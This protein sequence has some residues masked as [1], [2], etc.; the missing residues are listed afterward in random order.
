[1][2]RRWNAV[3]VAVVVIG[4][5]GGRKDEAKGTPTGKVSDAG[6]SGLPMPALGVEAP[7][8]LNYPYGSGAND[9][10]RAVAAYKAKPRDWT[11]VRSACEATLAKDKDH[12]DAHRLLASA[13]AQAGD[14]AGATQQLTIA[15]AADW[16][17][18]G[19]ALASDPELAAYLASPEGKA[20]LALSDQMKQA[21][22][23]KSA[24]GLVVLGRRS[25]FKRPSK[26]G[27]QPAFSRGELYAL[28]LDSKRYI[29]LTH[30]DHQAVAFLRSPDGSE[31]AVIG[32]DK[33]NIPAPAEAD[34]VAPLLVRSWI[35]TFDASWQP[36]GKR[37]IIGKGRAVA[38]HYGAGG[39]LLATVYAPKHRWQLG[40]ATTFSV[41]RATG[42]VAKTRTPAEIGPRAMMTFD[43]TIVEEPVAGVEA[44]WGEDPV[45]A[46]SFRITASGKTITVPDSAAA[47][48]ATLAISPGGT[49]VAFATWAD[50]CM[51]EKGAPSLYT[52]D[53][54]TGQPKH[55]LTA[56]SRFGSRWLDESRLVYEDDTGNLRIYDAAAGRETLRIA[57]R[58]G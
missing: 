17:R 32:Y 19:P 47:T 6:S 36:N 40:D 45:T 34:E 28:D 18:W 51:K 7:K 48:R 16:L 21:V 46:T 38:V 24:S 25:T 11:G 55:L 39:Q 2:L 10:Q 26:P 35:Q 5:G 29:R 42:K 31:V 20:L 54:A 4:C 43:D 37:A 8:M 56:D 1:M 49:R 30:T 52:V 53:V 12:L 58:G 44:D 3:M 22:L 9:Y 41:D 33:V 23:Q 50:P 27:D 57:D 13:L 15:L 14:F